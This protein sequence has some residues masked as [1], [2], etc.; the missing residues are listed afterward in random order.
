MSPPA[1]VVFRCRPLPERHAG[2]SLG[3]SSSPVVDANL[4]A[5][6]CPMR[7]ASKVSGDQFSRLLDLIRRL[8]DARISHRLVSFR[9]DSICVEVVVAGERWEVEFMDYGGVE[10]ERF[11]SDGEIRDEAELEA[12]FRDFSD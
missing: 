7:Q 1:V 10:V 6:P 12:L 3:T 11:R 9:P 5:E 2:A 4:G 8:E